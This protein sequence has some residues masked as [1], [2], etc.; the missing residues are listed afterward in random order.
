MKILVFTEGTVIMH[1]AAEGHTREER[2]E[3]SRLGGIQREEASLAYNSKDDVPVEYGSV[4]DYSNYI[5]IGNAVK[6]LTGWSN[7]GAEIHYLTSRRVRKEIEAIKSLLQKHNFPDFE[8][9]HFR[10]QGENYKDVAERIIP[11]VL[12]EDDCESIG[13]GKE[14]VYPHIKPEL[15][16]KIKSVVVKEFGGI[17]DLPENLSELICK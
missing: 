3:Q 7:Q 10:Q 6:K 2:V 9:L 16:N 15:K 1:K 17:D 13:G 14:M 5:P 11:D 12:I 8:N 4:H